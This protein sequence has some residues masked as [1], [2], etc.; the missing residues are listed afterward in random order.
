MNT[1]INFKK[2]RKRNKIKENKSFKIAKIIMFIIFVLHAA[3]ILSAF[4]WMI[5][6]TLKEQM[7]FSLNKFGLPQKWL[8]SNYAKAFETLVDDATDTSVYKMIFNSLWW[9]LGGT[10]LTISCSVMMSYAIAKFKFRGRDF[11]YG[12]ALFA[13][14]LPIYG[15]MPANMALLND[16]GLYNNPLIL[17]TCCNGLTSHF[18]M[19]YAIFK[20][21]SWSYAEAAYI[22]GANHF[23]VFFKVM[24]PMA[25]TPILALW[26]MMIM[27]KWND[28]MTC[29]IYFPDWLTL[30]AG[31]FTYQLIH[32]RDA[33]TPVLFAG[34][35]I[36]MIPPLFLFIALQNKV[37]SLTIA[38]GLKG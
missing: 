32:V 6:S 13:M 1:A 27:A 8:F 9:A 2:N 24:L 5:L 36:C 25:R 20:S 35:V 31:L 38:G 3:T 19:L 4:A 7:E 21:V 26:I 14:M 11:L 34:L 18:V 12:T 28:Y 22:D 17:I 16:L 29:I 15:A 33:N 10:F 37:S 30:S 23:T